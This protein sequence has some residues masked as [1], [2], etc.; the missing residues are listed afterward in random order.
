MLSLESNRLIRGVKISWFSVWKRES[1]GWK[2]VRKTKMDE[3]GLWGSRW[4]SF[5]VDKGRIYSN[6]VPSEKKY[7]NFRYMLKMYSN[8]SAYIPRKRPVVFQLHGRAKGAES[9]L[10][11][12]QNQILGMVRIP[13]FIS[14]HLSWWITC[15]KYISSQYFRS[16]YSA[17]PHNETKTINN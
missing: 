4:A 14:F 16:I 8:M 17:L 3:R 2:R 12:K 9:P 5:F 6:S 15:W 7:S 13:S 11:P 10:F 1:N